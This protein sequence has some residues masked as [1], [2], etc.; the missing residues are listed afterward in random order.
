MRTPL[1]PRLERLLTQVQGLAAQ[2]PP[3][4]VH[5]YA[6]KATWKPFV[7]DL[8]KEAEDWNFQYWYGHRICEEDGRFLFITRSGKLF[9]YECIHKTWV[10]TLDQD[11][12]L[13]FPE[14]L[15]ATALERI[16]KNTLLEPLQ[17]G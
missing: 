7:Q 12:L 16:I 9:T 10:C 5:Q 14:E 15:V 1:S 17:V 11:S 13:R 6:D 8:A 2:L 3:L 4:Q